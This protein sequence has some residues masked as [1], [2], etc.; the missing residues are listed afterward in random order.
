MFY[1]VR[2]NLE[3]STFTRKYQ[4][5]QLML[6]FHIQVSCGQTVVGSRLSETA[7]G[8]ESTQLT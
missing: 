3:E 7:K 4:C 1:L 8:K 6:L 2:N 5:E